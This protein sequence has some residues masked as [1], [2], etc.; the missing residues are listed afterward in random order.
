MFIKDHRKQYSLSLVCEILQL[1]SSGYHK[2]LKKKVS[3][4]AIENQLILEVI[5][6]HHNK[7]K[8]TC[9][10]PGIFAA[11]RKEGWL[12]LAVVMD[13]YSRKIAG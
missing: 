4:R 12:Y 2:W 11:M 10:L 6:F 9:G 7:S 5:R 13:L 8:A 1:S 3:F